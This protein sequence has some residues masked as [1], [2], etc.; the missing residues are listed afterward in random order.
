MQTRDVIGFVA[1]GSFGVWWLLSPRTVL[2]FY[3]W[4]HRGRARMPG[5]AGVRIAGVLWLAIIAVVF[6]QFRVR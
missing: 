3:G 5:P 1:F 4:F 2:R 6:W